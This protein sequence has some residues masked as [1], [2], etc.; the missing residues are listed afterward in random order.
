MRTAHSRPLSVLLV[1]ALGCSRPGPSPT[2]GVGES[3]PAPASGTKRPATSDRED[4]STTDRRSDQVTV[5]GKLKFLMVFGG[6]SEAGL[7]M[8]PPTFFVESE[9][10]TY[11][12]SLDRNCELVNAEELRGLPGFERLVLDDTSAAG[13]TGS[14]PVMEAPGIVR[15]RGAAGN[16]KV[17]ICGK[18]VKKL[19]ATYIEHVNEDANKDKQPATEKGSGGGSPTSGPNHPSIEAGE[20][21]AAKSEAQM[22][23]EAR[24]FAPFNL[25]LLVDEEAPACYM[26]RPNDKSLYVGRFT[27]DVELKVPGWC[28][29]P[30]EDAMKDHFKSQGEASFTLVK[31]A[32][33]GT[34]P[35]SGGGLNLR[36]DM[37]KT[38]DLMGRLSKRIIYVVDTGKTRFAVLAGHRYRIAGVQ[39]NTESHEGEPNATQIRYLDILSAEYLGPAEEKATEPV[40]QAPA[41]DRK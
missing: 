7:V 25:T 4:Q 5:E 10:G 23:F 6:L 11:L 35:R 34:H 33:P 18:E 28:V 13:G 1:I 36:P 19:R 9:G 32:P 40:S 37:D 41:Q 22:R 24:V 15:V 39:K 14:G 16:T 38:A 17:I 26:F 27:S 3:T 21:A 2:G 31:S 20:L 29:N 8:R 30:T 12:L